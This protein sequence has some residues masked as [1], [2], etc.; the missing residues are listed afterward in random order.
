MF[1]AL[2]SSPK[3]IELFG[4]SNTNPVQITCLTGEGCN[5]VYTFMHV[6][7]EETI[8]VLG[9]LGSSSAYFQNTEKLKFDSFTQLGYLAVWSNLTNSFKSVHLWEMEE[10]TSIYAMTL[11]KIFCCLNTSFKNVNKQ[12]KK[13]LTIYYV[14]HAPVFWPCW[15][16]ILNVIFCQSSRAVSHKELTAYSKSCLALVNVGDGYFSGNY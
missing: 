1:Q 2:C 16:E 11:F 4:I 14:P 10:F 3:L 8:E 15:V 13:N 5:L 12:K 9:I 6:D 7:M